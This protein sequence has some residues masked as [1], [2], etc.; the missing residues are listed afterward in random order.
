MKRLYPITENY[1]K[2]LLEIEPGKP[3][4]TSIIE[5]IEET[6]IG[7]IHIVTN[8]KFYNDYLEWE[9]N[10]ELRFDVDVIDDRTKS[11]DDRLGAIGDIVFALRERKLKGPIVFD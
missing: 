10:L 8:S 9:R 6:G 3:T 1:S 11:L 4:I 5:K 7:N 2:P